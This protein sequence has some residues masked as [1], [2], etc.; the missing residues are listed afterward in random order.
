MNNNTSMTSHDDSVA[1]TPLD[2]PTFH[3]DILDKLMY[4]ADCD[5]AVPL[6]S[7]PDDRYPYAY[8]RD[9]ASITKAWLESIR[10]GI[11]HEMCREHVRKTS[12]FFLAV[13]H[14]DG[15][16]VQRYAL[17]GT[18]KGIYEQEDNVGHGLRILAHAVF[19]HAETDALSELDPTYRQSIVDAVEQAVTYTRNSLFDPNAH[20]IE[21]T[22]SIH[23]CRIESGYTLWVNCVFVA[24]LRQAEQALSLLPEQTDDLEASI[25]TFRSHLESGVERAFTTSTQVPRRYSPTGE[26]DD[27]PDITLFAPS[28]FD[29]EDLFGDRL[30]QAANRAA[31]SLDDPELGGVQRFMGFYRDFDVHQHGGNG[32]WMQYTGWHAQYRFA[33]GEAERGTDVLRTIA[34]NATDEG[35]IPEHLTTSARFEAFVETEWETGLDFEKEFDED[36]LRDVSFD[37]IAEEL[38]HMRRAYEDLRE[39][40]KT[41]EVVAF[42]T[43]LAWCHAEYLMALLLR[44]AE[45]ETENEAETTV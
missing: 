6:A 40:T 13:Q 15:R 32:P 42:A 19:A 24:A 26:R 3:L 12:Q 41:R 29:L 4:P 25:E 9:I 10:A 34:E 44:D 35:H 31:A 14:D 8:P 22:T 39:Q 27:R 11:K 1:P 45:S 23:E 43:P 33:N 20:L 18:D 7:D 36:V 38:G 16:W 21:S 30:H 5:G 2:D 17:D 37:F 28:Y